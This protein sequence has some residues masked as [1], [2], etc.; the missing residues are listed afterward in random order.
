MLRGSLVV[1]TGILSIIFLKSRLY[2][3]SW[4]GIGLIVIG[5][6]LVGLSS[7]L[8]ASNTPCMYFSCFALILQKLLVL[9]I[10]CWVTLWLLLL[11]FLL[12]FNLLLKKNC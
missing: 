2:P 10:P 3:H 4:V 1:F 8:Y 11:K 6:V 7:V 5:T 12:L 9:E